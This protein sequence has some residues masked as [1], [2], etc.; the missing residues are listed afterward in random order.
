MAHKKVYLIRHGMTLGN[1]EKR[2][3]GRENNEPLCPEGI[4]AVRKLGSR[5]PDDLLADIDRVFSSPL[6]RALQTAEI[7]FPGRKIIL[8]DDMTETDFGYF[9]GKNHAELDGDEIYQKWIDS[10]GAD[11]IPGAEKREDLTERSVRALMTAL[12]DLNSDENIVI[13]CHGGNIM[14]SLSELTGGGYY[15]FMTGNLGCWL[16]E[17]ETDDNGIVKTSY[18][19][20]DLGDPDGSDNRR[21]I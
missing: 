21:S 6:Q 20:A 7:L 3:I 4:M 2:Y 8:L 17:L 15:D 11:P 10:N 9:E 16:L 5:M 18:R 19:R 12:G 1:S 14:A 13:V